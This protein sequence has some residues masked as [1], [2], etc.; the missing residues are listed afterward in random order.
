[1]ILYNPQTQF[2]D[3]GG[4]NYAE[5]DENGFLQFYGD[6]RA[7]VDYNFDGASLERGAVAPDLVSWDT[8]D[9]IVP[10][11]DGANTLERL[12]KVIELNHG[13]AEETI[14]KPHVHWAPTTSDAG[15]VEWFLQWFAIKDTTYT[16]VATISVVQA[17]GGVAWVEQFAEFP[18]I[19]APAADYI[20]GTQMGFALYRDPGV[21]NPD[22]DYAAD[23]A[24]LTVGLHVRLN[25]IGSR[26]V[27]I[28]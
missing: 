27:L 14:I 24:L 10:A 17:A 7:W 20:I 9:I 2:G 8:S 15:S 23:A 3:V 21:G 11:F 26:E 18:D 1:M 16:G 12:S 4:G 25:T 19:A 22:D 6:G 5:F 28:K 13:W